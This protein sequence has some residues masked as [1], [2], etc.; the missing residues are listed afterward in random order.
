MQL[1]EAAIDPAFIDDNDP[2]VL[3]QLN[4]DAVDDMSCS[5]QPS[6]RDEDMGQAGATG[7]VGAT[8]HDVQP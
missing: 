7:S 3:L 4:Q 2:R 5:W 8:A 1:T 6:Q